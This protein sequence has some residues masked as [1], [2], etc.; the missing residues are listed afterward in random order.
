MSKLPDWTRSIRN[1]GSDNAP[2]ILTGIGVVGNCASLILAVKTTPTALYLIDEKK[3]E[4]AKDELTTKETVEACWKCYIPT[5]G[6]FLLST[7]CLIGSLSINSK[8]NMALSTAYSLA[9]NALIE[10]QR[11]VVETIGERKE[12]EIRKEVAKGE[13][14]RYPIVTSEVVDTGFGDCM[15][16]EPITKRYFRS[17]PTKIQEA[18]NRIN[19]QING[20][21]TAS[22]TD[23]LY[24]LHLSPIKTVPSDDLGWH[25]DILR[26]ENGRDGFTVD[27]QY[28]GDVN[29]FPVLVLDYSRT[30]LDTVMKEAWMHISTSKLA[31]FTCSVM[32]GQSNKY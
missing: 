20:E 12:S 11:K 16:F 1:W 21:D 15:C 29:G 7:A 28:D 25:V 30:R 31:Y 4:L 27:Y 10:Y 2:E 32:D 9:E 13:L 22:F 3:K 5:A 24:E 6:T 26:R 17:S 19:A 14:T 23:W 8:R 18:R